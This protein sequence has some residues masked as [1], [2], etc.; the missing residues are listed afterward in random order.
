MVFTEKNDQNS[1]FINCQ[2][3]SQK[4]VKS[5]SYSYNCERKSRNGILIVKYLRK[6]T[7]SVSV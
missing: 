4:Y 3:F 7:L 6:V 5:Y 1:L 2:V